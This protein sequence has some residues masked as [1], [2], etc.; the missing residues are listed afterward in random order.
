MCADVAY[1]SD[2]EHE[3]RGDVDVLMRHF[4]SPVL[5]GRVEEATGEA[6]REHDGCGDVVEFSVRVVDGVIERARFRCQG[7]S[8]SI[9]AASYLAER[10]TG[11][12][13]DAVHA[14]T[15]DGLLV[16]LGDARPTRRH[17]VSLALETL[18]DAVAGGRTG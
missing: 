18:R 1:D 5:V 13:T 7:C 12:S 6:R 15:T 3:K 17:G 8:A 10:A 11:S 14:W 16:D 2:M 9:G 4:R